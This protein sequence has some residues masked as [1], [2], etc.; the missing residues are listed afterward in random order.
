MRKAKLRY[1]CKVNIPLFSLS[2]LYLGESCLSSIK[3]LAHLV[4]S[5]LTI[6]LVLC[7]LG[8]A[9]LPVSLV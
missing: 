4:F 8:D 5:Q 9:S 7:L 2:P 1:L 6:L 3:G